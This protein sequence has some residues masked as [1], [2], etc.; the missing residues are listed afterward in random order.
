MNK[1]TASIAFFILILIGSP[2]KGQT[3]MQGKVTDERG[4]GVPG[5]NILIVKDFVQPTLLFYTLSDED[6]S[7][8]LRNNLSQDSLCV[9]VK[10]FNL[11]TIQRKVPNRSGT[12]NF[13][14]REEA[15]QLKEVTVKSQRVWGGKD[16]INYLVNSFKDKSDLTIGDVLKKLPGIHVN[17][18]GSIEYQGVPINKFYIEGL[19]LMKNRYGIA[20]NNISPDDVATVQ[21]LEHH[22]PVRALEKMKHSDQAAINLRLKDTAKGLFSLIAQLGVGYDDGGLGEIEL[23]G[24]YFTR[25]RQHLG[26]YKGNNDGKDIE[27]EMQEHNADASADL[28][29]HLISPTPPYIGKSHYYDNRSHI[30]TSNNLIKDHRGNEWN[31]GLFYFNDGEQRNSSSRTTYLLPDG[32]ANIINE[33]L[34]SS[35]EA[36]RLAGDVSYHLNNADRYVAETFKARMEWLKGD[37]S[38]GGEEPVDQRTKYKGVEIANRLHWIAKSD[39]YT[40]WELNSTLEFRNTPQDLFV[41]PG[42]FSDLFDP[43]TEGLH[44]HIDFTRFETQNTAAMLTALMLGKIRISPSI[45]ANVT[46]DRL[47]SQLQPVSPGKFTSI[48]S[49]NDTYLLEVKA[50]ASAI[51][52]YNSNAVHFQLYLPLLYNHRTLRQKTQDLKLQADK[53][54]FE[55]S[56]KLSFNWKRWDWGINYLL[57]NSH[58]GIEQLYSGRILTDY[59]NLSLY[60]P[61]WNDN[62]M[63]RTGIDIHYKHVYDLFFASLKAS[64]SRYT[65][66]M[67]YGQTFDGVLSRITAQEA[68]TYGDVIQAG[69]GL[70]KGFD[71]KKIN[72]EWQT[73]WIRRNSPILRQ[74]Q[75]VRYT[76]D[77]W[78]ME[79]KLYIAPFRFLSVNLSESWH[80]SWNRQQGGERFP[81][82]STLNTQANM[83]ISLPGNWSASLTYSNYYNSQAQGQQSFSLADVGVRY[84][85]KTALFSVEWNNLFDVR[86]YTYASLNNLSEYYS[87]YLIRSSAILLKARFKIR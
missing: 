47:S 61:A 87:E 16:T 76:S 66:T 29:T 58:A 73:Q 56:A 72:L 28:L 37:G 52:T 42:L 59:R 63:H 82:L 8:V 71:W 6:G 64:Y 45:V 7:F 34:S 1:C 67:L 35:T 26:I 32:K 18:S 30:L 86:S 53:C 54:I 31:I 46:Y 81:A 14:T 69:L 13:T 60:E 55:P 19:D 39:E 3:I 9:V 17:P 5:A 79:G 44:Q 2:A 40:G 62:R 24:S 49:D 11:R 65:A 23:I 21:V 38:V 4:H 48:P 22:Q 20:T 15:I 68:D 57:L 83:D 50:G 36:N 27:S 80:K 25:K 70:S 12:L 74:E 33:M 75:L 43:S 84:K 41:T 78:A 51:A 85:W 77:A 10:G